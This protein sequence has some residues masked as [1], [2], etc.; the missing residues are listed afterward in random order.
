MTQSLALQVKNQVEVN[1]LALIQI[2]NLQK[3]QQNDEVS[4][5]LVKAVIETERLDFNRN[6]IAFL[7]NLISKFSNADKIILDIYKHSNLSK[8]TIEIIKM[9]LNSPQSSVDLNTVVSAILTE[10]ILA[11]RTDS[12]FFT[13]ISLAK[14]FKL[15]NKTQQLILDHLIQ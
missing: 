6:H 3:E 1:P 7:V 4:A 10:M 8:F 13:L 11:Y 5:L 2:L 15:L 12:D 14:S 9:L